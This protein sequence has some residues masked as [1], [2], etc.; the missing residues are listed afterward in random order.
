MRA[1]LCRSWLAVLLGV[2]AAASV[3]ARSDSR[4]DLREIYG[5]AENVFQQQHW[6]RAQQLFEQVLAEAYFQRGQLLESQNQF[7]AAVADLEWAAKLRPRD[8]DVQYHLA[9]AYSG[10]RQY[11]GA[12]RILS[13]LKAREY[14][15]ADVLAALGRVQSSLGKFR[16]ARTDLRQAMALNPSDHLTAY[17]LGLVLLVQKELSAAAQVFARLQLAVGDSA[18]LRLLLG[19]AYFDNGFNQ[20][21]EAELRRALALDSTIHYA[22]HLLGLCALRQDLPGARDEAQRQFETEVHDYPGEEAPLFMLG[23]VLESK[24]DWAGARS[25]LDAAQK[26]APEEVDVYL[27]RGHVEVEAGDAAAA[28]D[29]EHW[30]VATPDDSTN[31]KSG[32]AHFL[33]SRAYLALGQSEKSVAEAKKA[34]SA[35]SKHAIWEREKMAQLLSPQASVKSSSTARPLVTWTELEPPNSANRTELEEMYTKVLANS[36]DRLGIIAAQRNDLEAVIHN[37][38]RVSQIQPDFPGIDFNLGLA[39]FRT[40][41]LAEAV[42][43]L[44]RAATK[45][46]KNETI[47]QLLARAEFEYGDCDAAIPELE[48]ALTSQPDDP[49]LLLS[50]GTCLGR[51][52]RQGEAEAVFKRLLQ[53]NSN[54]PELHMFLAQGAYALNRVDDARAE[55]NN[56]LALDPHTPDAHFYLGLIALQQADF[57]SAEREFRSELQSYQ[58]NQKVR[59]HLAFVLLRE[60]KEEEAVSLLEDIR[61]V[62]PGYAQAHYSL[63][64][65]LVERG[66]LSRGISELEE[67]VRDDPGKAYSHYQLG[68]AYMRAGKEADARREL[69]LASKLKDAERNHQPAAMADPNLAQ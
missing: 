44:D 43:A 5:S 41:R 29:L 63:G 56:T 67:A 68:R 21:A 6:N 9:L 14:R 46:A 22:H 28:A 39:A 24:R 27:H 20:Q 30:I 16:L 25:Y 11:E 51:A 7:G 64:K 47:R 60:E 12:E 17:T 2:W 34:Q 35:S 62:S 31:V 33:L 53:A 26:L 3:L 15:R 65:T 50:L 36:H 55:F 57:A 42:A 8:L 59:Y 1:C 61:K 4:P 69:E 37:F 18:R 38:E 66:Q 19:R 48:A 45:D 52:H 54:R 10:N 49:G 32:Q 40:N 13:N 58:D 23:V